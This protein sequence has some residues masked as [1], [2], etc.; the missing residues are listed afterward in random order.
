MIGHVHAWLNTQRRKK[1]RQLLD[2]AYQTYVNNIS[3]DAI[4]SNEIN[5][6][7]LSNDNINNV[8]NSRANN[9]NN[10]DNDYSIH[11]VGTLPLRFPSLTESISSRLTQ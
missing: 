7:S 2:K 8:Y 3:N 6:N 9:N 5:A 1:V 4:N 11:P 10:S